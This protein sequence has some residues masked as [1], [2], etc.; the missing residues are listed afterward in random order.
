MPGPSR[1]PAEQ[2]AAQGSKL[3]AERLAA[4]PD[5]ADGIPSPPDWLDGIALSEWQRI[6][7]IMAEAGTIKECDLAIVAMYSQAWGEYC[8]LRQQV[9]DKGWT[10]ISSKGAEYPAPWANYYLAAEKRVAAYAKELGITPAS[11]TKVAGKPK[12]KDDGDFF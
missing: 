4:Q 3:A 5:Y 7:A 9:I 11:H 1:I 10:A 8:E 12:Q 6:T 2:L